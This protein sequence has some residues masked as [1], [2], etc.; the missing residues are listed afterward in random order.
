MLRIINVPILPVGIIPSRRMLKWKMG[1][2]HHVAWTKRNIQSGHSDMQ[3]FRKKQYRNTELPRWHENPLAQMLR[4]IW[5]RQHNSD[6]CYRGV[7]PFNLNRSPI[8][9]SLFVADSI[10]TPAY[11]KGSQDFTIP[12]CALIVLSFSWFSLILLLTPWKKQ[13]QNTNGEELYY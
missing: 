4:V 11:P 6:S 7:P 13:K 1:L 12:C 10:P 9:D 2:R 5:T 3:E 8:C